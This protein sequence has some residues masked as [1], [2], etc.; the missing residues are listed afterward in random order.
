MSQKNGKNPVP[1]YERE[2][3]YRNCG[4][5]SL[6]GCG[7]MVLAAFF[8]W[9][10]II[11]RTIE[12]TYTGVS[13]YSAVVAALKGVSVKDADGNVVRSNFRFASVSPL[14]LLILYFALIL[15]MAYTAY[16]DNI[17][18]KPFLM[19][20]EKRVRLGMAA[21]TII[22]IILMTHTAYYKI[23]LDAMNELK[24]SW[25]SFIEMCNIN[26]LEGAHR[27]RCYMWP[28]PGIL[29]YILGL[30]AYIFSV[31]YNFILDTL[32]EDAL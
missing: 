30:G 14:I 21:L 11:I 28:G 16:N 26:H 6:A 7:L 9:K 17:S 20:W 4:I 12:K 8:Y 27:M 13:F 3:A 18:R 15:L 10:N 19:K 23:G 2:H 32:N 29:F 1:F 5:V 31:I 22:L 24:T 25:D